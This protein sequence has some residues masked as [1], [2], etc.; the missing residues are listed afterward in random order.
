MR[1][2]IQKQVNSMVEII[3]NNKEL[4]NQINSNPDGIEFLG[5]LFILEENVNQ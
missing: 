1:T 2:T 3:R 4:F 5:K